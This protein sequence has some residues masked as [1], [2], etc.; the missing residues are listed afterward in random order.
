[1]ISESEQVSCVDE[2]VAEQE[3]FLSAAIQAKMCWTAFSAGGLAGAGV[4]Q[5]VV[6]PIGNGLV[7]AS[8]FSGALMRRRDRGW[9]AGDLGP[10][11]KQDRFELV[12]EPRV[13]ASGENCLP[14]P[15]SASPT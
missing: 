2:M 6:V 13:L 12:I 8:I 1:M 4:V 11:S 14:E 5:G 3:V 10:P 9:V 7:L 15:D